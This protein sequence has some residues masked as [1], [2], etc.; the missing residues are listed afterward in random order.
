MPALLA[1]AV[2]WQVLGQQRPRA[3]EAH[4]TTEHIPELRQ[5]VEAGLS[6]KPADW[7][8][9]PG[10]GQQASIGTG[11]RRHCPEL[12][13][14]EWLPTIAYSA[15][16]ENHRRPHGRNDHGGDGRHNW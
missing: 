7:S 14:Y 4:F 1:R 16:A 13:Q 10:V 15:M 12:I 8:Q 3:N 2:P 11:L 9:S 5:L 6:E